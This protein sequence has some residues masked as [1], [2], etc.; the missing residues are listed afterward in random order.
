MDKQLRMHGNAYYEFI[1]LN[2]KGKFVGDCVIRAIALACGQ[3]WEQTIREMTELGIKK[4]YE[5]N[6]KKFI[7][8]Y[9]KAKGFTKMTEPRNYD[10]KKITVREWL[11]SRDYH[12]W[13]SYKI[14]ANVGSCHVSCIIE[15]KVHDTWDCSKH[16]MHTWWVK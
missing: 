12:L 6:D 13:H 4:G 14:V 7:P 3:T 8:I 15:G 1:N 2:P 5:L 10:N 16:T 9:L 11:C